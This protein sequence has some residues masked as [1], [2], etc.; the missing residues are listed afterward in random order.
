M[1]S[2]KLEVE[3]VNQ[4][5]LY[6][7]PLL[8]C[9][10]TQVHFLALGTQGYRSSVLILLVCVQLRE[11]RHVSLLLELLLLVLKVVDGAHVEALDLIE[12]VYLLLVPHV[13]I[14]RHLLVLITLL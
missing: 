2:L 14:V 4:R 11:Y 13:H 6:I 9:R 1:E 3:G 8:H 12:D 5:N 7:I 10:A